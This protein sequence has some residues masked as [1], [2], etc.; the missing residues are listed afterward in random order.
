VKTFYEKQG[1]PQWAALRLGIPTASEFDS[2]VTPDFKRRTGEGPKTYLYR[3]ACERL[4]GF[5]PEG[6]GT[7][8]MEQGVIGE[9]EALPYYEFTYGVKI[10]RVGFCTTDDGRIGCSPDGL[11][12]TDGGIEVKTPQP[13]THLKYLMDGG[14]PR[15]YLAQVH[16][17]LLVT[18]RKWWIFMSYSRQ[19]APLVVKVERNEGIIAALRGAL[20]D[21]LD[22]FDTTISVIT[23]MRDA[24]NAIKQAEHD[25]MNPTPDT[26]P[27]AP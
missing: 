25:R 12:G 23:K 5:A 19:F 4:L 22:D 14:V 11:I 20:C 21:F 9:V 3:K 27:A 16:G 15:D 13:H 7:W 26:T 24:E 6:G 10:D 1:T 2:L 18:G 17:A 8:A